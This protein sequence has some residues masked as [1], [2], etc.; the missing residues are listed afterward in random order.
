MVNKSAQQQKRVYFANY[1]INKGNFL[2]FL[3][4][5]C[6]M[7]TKP[8]TQTNDNSHE[9]MTKKQQQKQLYFKCVSTYVVGTF[10]PEQFGNELLC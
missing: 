3:P 10:Y 7:K 4:V 1:K 2:L 9:K 5:H 6:E 8:T